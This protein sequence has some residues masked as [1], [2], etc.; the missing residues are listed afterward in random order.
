[1]PRGI[2]FMK[3]LLS[4]QLDLDDGPLSAE[5][6]ESNLEGN[7]ARLSE[8]VSEEGRVVVIVDGEDVCG[9]YSEPLIRL[10]DQWLRKVNWLIS[11]DTETLPFRNSEQCFGFVPTGKGVEFSFYDGTE[12]EIEE[13]I[14]EPVLFHL[15][16]LVLESVA[17]GERVETLLTQVNPE[18]VIIDSDCADLKRALEELKASWRNHQLHERR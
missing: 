9:D 12:L 17:L 16:R 6:L 5:E 7:L 18:L 14:V 1:M 3:L 2:I 15:E 4:Y 8:I 11:G 10:V 13:Y